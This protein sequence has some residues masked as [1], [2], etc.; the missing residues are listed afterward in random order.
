MCGGRWFRRNHLSRSW[1]VG[2]SFQPREE[3]AEGEQRKW[4]TAGQ[5]RVSGWHKAERA[6]NETGRRSVQDR[7]T[8]V[9]RNS[10]VRIIQWRLFLDG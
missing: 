1:W 3:T 5:A 7:T 4:E 2:G 8:D 6:I 10:R 9:L